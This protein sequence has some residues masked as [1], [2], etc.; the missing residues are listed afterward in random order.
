MQTA[1]FLLELGEERQKLSTLHLVE[2]RPATSCGAWS[3]LTGGLLAP[4]FPF[5]ALWDFPASIPCPRYSLPAPSLGLAEKAPSSRKPTRRA[6]SETIDPFLTRPQASA[7]ASFREW[8][9]LWPTCLP[10]PTPDRMQLWPARLW[11]QES[12]G[13]EAVARGLVEWGRGPAGPVPGMTW[14]R[15]NPGRGLS[16]A[17]RMGQGSKGQ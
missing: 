4:P 2:G 15:G 9:W 1:C 16:P 5:P 14:D 10:R 11:C 7:C 17:P 12:E 3:I 13:S 6:P 8:A